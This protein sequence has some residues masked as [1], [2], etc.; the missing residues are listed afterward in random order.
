MSFSSRGPGVGGL[1]GVGR[2]TATTVARF[3]GLFQILPSQLET[4]DVGS[5]PFH[6]F[7]GFVSRS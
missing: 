4:S 3:H 5:H 7:N 2:T 1:W 6:P